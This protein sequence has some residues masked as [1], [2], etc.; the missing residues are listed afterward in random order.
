MQIV[1][2]IPRFLHL[3][4]PLFLLPRFGGARPLAGFRERSVG[5][6]NFPANV[7]D[8]SM[9]H[10]ALPRDRPTAVP[11]TKIEVGYRS[12]EFESTVH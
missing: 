4:L 1:G 2:Y 9:F 12:K 11:G 10:S 3:R 7:T 5:G 6:G 8:L